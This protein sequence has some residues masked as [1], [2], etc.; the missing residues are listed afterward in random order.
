MPLLRKLTGLGAVAGRSSSQPPAT[1]RAFNSIDGR[2][3]PQAG[4]SLDEE[5]CPLASTTG[6]SS[7]INQVGDLDTQAA[8]KALLDVVDELVREVRD[9]Q[10]QLQQ[11]RSELTALR[12]R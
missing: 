1:S 3:K 11:T 5:G 2:A 4:N 12:S 9:L 10:N 8:L 7:K 6:V